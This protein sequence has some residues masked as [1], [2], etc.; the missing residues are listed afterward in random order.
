MFA[1]VGGGGLG[2]RGVGEQEGRSAEPSGR[3]NLN[4]EDHPDEARCEE[5]DP[6]GARAHDAQLRECVLPVDLPCGDN[7]GS[8]VPGRGGGAQ[9]T[10]GHKASPL[11]WESLCA[12]RA[13]ARTLRDAADDLPRQDEGRGGAEH[14]LGRPPTHEDLHKR[15]KRAPEQAFCQL[16]CRE[17]A[18]N[19]IA[20]G[21]A[22]EGFRNHQG[23]AVKVT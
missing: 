15:A 17:E 6:E 11:P 10:C 14:P 20:G 21:F 19:H 13:A 3:L 1:F 16:V 12:G 9:I 8:M 5:A 22:C 2:S 23:A 18:G 7:R 4:C